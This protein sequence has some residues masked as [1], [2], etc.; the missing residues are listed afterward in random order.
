MLVPRQRLDVL[1]EERARSLAE[2][3]LAATNDSRALEAQDVEK[4]DTDEQ[5]KRFAHQI[6]DKAGSDLWAREK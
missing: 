4:G 6:I 1:I 2:K 3:R 5:F